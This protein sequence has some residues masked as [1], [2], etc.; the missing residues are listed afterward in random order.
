MQLIGEAYTILK[1]IG[2]LDNAALAKTF[3]EWNTGELDSFLIDITAKI[4]AKKDEECF[5][6]ATW[7]ALE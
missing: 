1:T 6:T 2:G 4:L 7:K 3:A 5:D